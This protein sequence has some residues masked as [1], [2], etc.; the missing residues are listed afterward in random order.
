MNM[1]ERPGSRCDGELHGGGACRR[2]TGVP[3]CSW[4]RTNTENRRGR[5]SERSKKQEKAK[6][7]GEYGPMRRRGDVPPLTT[8]LINAHVQMPKQTGRRHEGLAQIT[9]AP[10]SITL[11]R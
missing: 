2:E 6:Q 5:G 8:R 7:N 11:S 9:R 3:V 10:A 4:D 1:E